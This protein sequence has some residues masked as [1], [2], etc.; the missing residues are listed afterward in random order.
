ME[1]KSAKV[2]KLLEIYF[3]ADGNNQVVI[4]Q[5]CKA[6]MLKIAGC[7]AYS[8]KQFDESHKRF[9]EAKEKFKQLGEANLG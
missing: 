2:L 6:N 9:D 1:A 4:D 3:P 7:L 5:V 8:K